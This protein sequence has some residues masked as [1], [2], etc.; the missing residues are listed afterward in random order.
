MITIE[1]LQKV[2]KRQLALRRHLD[3]DNGIIKLKKEKESIRAYDFW[4]NTKC[5]KK[6]M[7]DVSNIKSSINAYK[8]IQESVE[9]LCLAF[10]FNKDGIIGEEEVDEIYKNVI[11]LL[12]DLE[13]K[14]TLRSEEDHF[15][16]ILKINAGAGGVE[17]QD[18][19]E[20]LYRMYSRWS[21]NKKYKVT[22]INYLEGDDAG[23]KK[24]TL[25]VDGDYAFGYL[26]SE[27]GV[28][29]LVRVSPYNAKGKRMTSFASVSVVPLVDDTIEINVNLGDITWDTFRSSGA[30]GQ[31]VNKVETGV[32]L[33]Y[34]HKNFTTGKIEEII[35]ENTESRS[36]FTNK[37]NA[38]R[39]LKS[40]LYELE[41]KKR[42]QTT[43]K[44][45]ADKKKIE[46]GSQ[47]RSYIFDDKRIKDHRTGWQTTNIQSVM[48]GNIDDLISAYLNHNN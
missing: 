15:G 38:I 47:I 39:L 37:N 16:A 43:M 29:R 18:W 31:N 20:M 10:D 36:Q 13:L 32:R 26:K 46:W 3:V 9:E 6:Q 22:V 25:Q 2:V 1:Q 7:K 19:V 4:E 48:D 35:I 27:N 30:G 28:H 8:K 14:N 12:G 23:I 44:I 33:H 40:Q 17:A 34:N 24:V 5:A 41:L 11:I 21:E 42:R 45:E